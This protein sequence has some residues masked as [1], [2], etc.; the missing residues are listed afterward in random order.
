MPRTLTD[1]GV[2]REKLDLLAENCPKVPWLKTNPIPLAKKEQVLD[3]L[4]MVV[5]DG[6]SK[7]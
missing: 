4:E 3:I 6:K 7:L 5:D 1:V 2:G